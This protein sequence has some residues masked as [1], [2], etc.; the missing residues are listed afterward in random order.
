MTSFFS[1]FPLSLSVS[2]CNSLYYENFPIILLVL[3]TSPLFIIRYLLF[4]S[5]AWYAYLLLIY[6]VMLRCVYVQEKTKYQNNKMM[7]VMYIHLSP[8]Y[9]LPISPL[10]S[11]FKLEVCRLA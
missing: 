8:I 4:Y 11:H 2:L 1:F 6:C 9:H 3:H 5:I 7:R 10:N